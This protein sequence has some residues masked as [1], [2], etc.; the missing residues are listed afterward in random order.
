LKATEAFG[1]RNFGTMEFD[2]FNTAW[3][4]RIKKRMDDADMPQKMIRFM[5]EQLKYPLPRLLIS[6]TGGARDFELSTELEQV[7]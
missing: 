5:T 7:L 6:V 4:I 1:K 3:Y 2:N